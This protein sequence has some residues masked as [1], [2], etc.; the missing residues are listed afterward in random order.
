MSNGL[1]FKRLSALG[2]VLVRGLRGMTQ[3]FHIQA[4]AVGTMA[5]CMLLLG[6]AVLLWTNARGIARDWGID[7]PVTVY[8]VDGA[9]PEHTAAL[10]HK[11]ARIDEVD[12]VVRVTP[13]DA[14]DR[15]VHGLGGQESLLEGIDPETLPA[16]LEIHLRPT[17]EPE[18]GRR[19]GEKLQ[20][21]DD[22]EEVA[23]V[24]PWAQQARNMLDTLRMLSLGV[25]LLVSI[26]CMAI[27][28]STIRL[29]VFARRAE[30]HIFRLVGGTHAFVRGPFVV[31]GLLQGAIGAA[32]ALSLLAAGFDVIRPHLQQGLAMI[33]AAG[34]LRFFTPME[35][36]VGV[37][38]GALV[39]FLGARA[40]VS[41]YVEV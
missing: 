28:W 33:F 21:H 12:R 6:T 37:G 9:E 31:E 32:L 8:M 26:A 41:R 17:V 40:A 25:G 4:L 36:A 35:I 3:S 38:F 30:I 7:V 19:L 10:E 15:L 18:F 14:M 27:V 11:L 13:Q 20:A 5:V 16:S 1:H 2:Y 23:V 39:G 34:G 24:G 29:G 22:V